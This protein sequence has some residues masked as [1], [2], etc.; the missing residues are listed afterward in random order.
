MAEEYPKVRNLDGVYNRAIRDGR[1]CTLCFTDLTRE[2]QEKFLLK[3]NRTGLKKMC[4]IMADT[5]RNV[6]DQLDLVLKEE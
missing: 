4:L 1:G 3:L 5:L 2:E 6:G